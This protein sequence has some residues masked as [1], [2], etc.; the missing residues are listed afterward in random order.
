LSVLMM[1]KWIDWMVR[2][3]LA[4]DTIGEEVA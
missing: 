2:R 3:K 4:A 1:G